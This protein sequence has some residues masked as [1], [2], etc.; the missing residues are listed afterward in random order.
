MV[1]RPPFVRPRDD[2]LDS[3][4]RWL[5]APTRSSSSG[6]DRRPSRGAAG[7]RASSSRP[8]WRAA[9]LDA[10]AVA[11]HGAA[12][13][14]ALA[15]A[16]GVPFMTASDAL[17]RLVAIGEVE[18]Q[19]NPADRRSRVP[20]PPPDGQRVAAVDAPLRRAAAAVR[21]DALSDAV[22][23]LDDALGEAL[24]ELSR[25]RDTFSACCSHSPPL[26]LAAAP[27]SICGGDAGSPTAGRTRRDAGAL[28]VCFG[29]D[30]SLQ[31]VRP[32]DGVATA[33]VQLDGFR[34]WAVAGGFGS[35]W[36]IDREQPALLRLDPATGRVLRRVSCPASVFLGAGDRLARPREGTRVARVEPATGRIRMVAAGDGASGFASDGRSVW[37]VSHRDNT[38]TR[39]DLATNRSTRVASA[40]TPSRR[41]PPIDR[42]RGRIALDHRPRPRPACASTRRRERSRRRSTSA[43][44]G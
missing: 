7:R 19:P 43:L 15:A 35:L 40:V 13:T 1:G 28:W 14:T 18:Q 39:V 3:F 21:T 32:R 42:L 25:F 8:A 17:Q 4:R 30:E 6:L 33:T 22:D 44:P 26:A 12:T 29:D 31:R 9:A 36:A 23:R 41:P 2:L 16:L 34:P 20:A 24:A 27:G 38:L 37:I 5:S 10:A 11:L